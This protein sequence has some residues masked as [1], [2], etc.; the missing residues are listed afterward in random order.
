[1]H[2]F[3]EEPC[4]LCLLVAIRHLVRLSVVRCRTGMSGRWQSSGVKSRA[5]STA[6]TV[7]ADRVAIA[8][9]R[10]E[11]GK[12]GGEAIEGRGALRLQYRVIKVRGELQRLADQFAHVRGAPGPR[13]VLDAAPSLER[14]RD[15]ID[16]FGAEAFVLASRAR[17]GGGRCVGGRERRFGLGCMADRQ[18]DEQDGHRCDAGTGDE[19]HRGTPVRALSW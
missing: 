14:I 6:A 2:R 9:R 13:P 19:H 11:V 8:Q 17:K 12:V 3:A 7:G 10:I 5:S 4:S 16:V 18:G 15:R 1:M